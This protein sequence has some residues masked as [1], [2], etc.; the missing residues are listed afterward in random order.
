LHE[1][2]PLWSSPQR[3]WFNR[4]D[5]LASPFLSF[6]NVRYALHDPDHAMP[7]HW[8][9]VGSAGQLNIIENTAALPRAFMP[10]AVRFNVPYPAVIDEMRNARDFRAMSWINQNHAP[11]NMETNGS[12]T[13][14]ITRTTLSTYAIHAEVARDGWIVISQAAWKGWRASEGRQEIPVRV[15]NHAFLAIKL[16]QGHHDVDLVFRPHGF[17]VGRAITFVTLIAV[18]ILG[19]WSRHSA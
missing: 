1:T 6:L 8:R 16:S 3:N 15:A 2:Y 17:I 13:V 9:V 11:H 19:L 12:G 18:V 4:I 14:S 5:S 10:A 7:L